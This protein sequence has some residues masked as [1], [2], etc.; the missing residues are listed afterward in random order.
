MVYLRKRARLYS[1]YTLR[2]LDIV[3]GFAIRTRV[4]AIVVGA[5]IIPL[6]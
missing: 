4:G 6:V 5:L 1:N 2:V 3:G